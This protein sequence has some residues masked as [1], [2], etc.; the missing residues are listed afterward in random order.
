MRAKSLR[1]DVRKLPTRMCTSASRGQDMVEFALVSILGMIFLFV[2]VQMAMIGQASLALG[3]VSYQGAR[4]AAVNSSA[5]C[6]QVA[7]YMQSIS[8]VIGKGG[9]ACGSGCASGVQIAMS[10]PG[11]GACGNGE[12]R[13]F[14]EAVQISACFNAKSLLFLSSSFFGIPFPTSL[15]STETAISE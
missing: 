14:G 11:V 13:S 9:V 2:V 15:S 10:C 7:S 1:T 6:S 3:H 5:T 4:Y 8:P 12:T